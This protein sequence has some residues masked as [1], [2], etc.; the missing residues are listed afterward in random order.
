MKILGVT[1]GIGSGKSTLC[2]LLVEHAS[3]QLYSADLRARELMNHDSQLRK[4]IV[5]AFGEECYAGGELNRGYLSGV[6]FGDE[7]QL[8]RLNSIVHPRVRVDF[9]RWAQECEGD[10]AIMESAILF[11]SGFDDLTHIKVAVLAP[12]Q[13]RVERVCSRDGVSIEAVMSRIEAQMSDDELQRRADLCVVNIFE[14]DLE[15]SAQRIVKMVEQ[16]QN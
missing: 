4:D 6:V 5:E 3:A 10:F 1:G 7:E 12:T 11:E 14:E 15:A 8:R 2:R 13:L 9:E 16:W